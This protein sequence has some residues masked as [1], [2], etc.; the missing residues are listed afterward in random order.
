MRTR[1]PSKDSTVV[2][3]VHRLQHI[4]FSLFGSVDRLEAVFAV[5]GVVA[6]GHIEILATNMRR[7][8]LLVAKALLDF[9]EEIFKAQTQ[10]RTLRQPKRKTLSYE[11]GEHEEFHLLANLAMVAT[12]GFFKKL[13]IL[14]KHLL[15]REGDT[16]DTRHL[17]TL[18]IATPVG[19]TYSHH[20]DS[21]DGSGRHQVRATAKV[22]I[23]TLG[24]G[25]D[26]A[27]LKFFNQL[28]LIRLSVLSEE[29][30]R[31][32]LGNIA[33]Y[34]GFLASD[35][36]LHLLF[37]QPKVALG[38]ADAFGGHHVIIESIFDS[39]TDTKLR[40]RPQFLH[41][42]SHKVGRSVPEGMLCF[43]VVPLIELD[44]G[45][46]R[47]RTIQFNGL[48]VD[49]TYQNILCQTRGNTLGN[50]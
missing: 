19:G 30:K 22:R 45:I 47:N 43:G 49:T 10:S 50:L 28:I 8:H 16:V 36:F 32:S 31:V 27:V 20:L 17:R 25:G 29:L 44:G 38:D 34:E 4:L 26:M 7:H 14:I 11:F 2:G 24:I 46:G 23:L 33:T 48:T 40:T 1:L 6:R 9:L 18:F 42:F 13:E 39:R 3:A 5:F 21:L 15:L 12:L 41:S 35:E 37:N